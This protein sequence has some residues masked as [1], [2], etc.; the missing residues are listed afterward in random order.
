[1]VVHRRFLILVFAI[2]LTLSFLYFFSSWAR[3]ELLSGRSPLGRTFGI[4]GWVA[5]CAACGSYAWQ[6][7]RKYSK[8]AQDT[9]HANL[10]GIAL[11]LI[12]LHAS[13]RFDNLI[14]A[15]AALALFG[16]VVSGFAVKI[17]E[18][19]LVQLSTQS[20]NTAQLHAATLRYNHL[21]QRWL[22][23]HIAVISGLLTFTVVHI[24]SVLYYS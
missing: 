22:T 24:L 10:G 21:R 2:G 9:W 1:M 20:A 23:T 11:W 14:A 3:P 8:E 6:R 15:L 13:F 4:L 16:G 18:R 19:K 5:S 12:L 17:Y 7:R